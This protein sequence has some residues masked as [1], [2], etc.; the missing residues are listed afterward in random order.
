MLSKDF[1]KWTLITSI[2]FHVVVVLG[3]SF[4]MPT[5]EDNPVIGPPLRI[6]LVSS[7]SELEPDNTETLAQANSAGEEDAAA[8]IPVQIQPTR[9][10]NHSTQETA[11]QNDSVLDS[12]FSESFITE[13]Q[14]IENLDSTQTPLT[15]EQLTQE[16]NLA[17]LNAQAQPREKYVSAR[18]K[19]SIYAA[20][21]EKWRLLVERV[22]NLNY[23]EAAKQQKLEGT[24]VLD[25]A[26]NHRGDVEKVRVLSSSGIKVLD[27]AATRIVHI[28]SP[29]DRFPDSIKKEID[30]LH[31][32]RTWE[33][34][35]DQSSSK[36]GVQ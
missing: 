22:G 20:Y 17:Y 23:P 4:V 16:I 29:Y 32:V 8:S 1:F 10:Q 21:L 2:V 14:K 13:S 28:A 25:V 6:T 3:I 15:R 35:Q 31:I 7:A 11:E 18:A 5:Q 12:A 9:L 30:I 36:M 24:L 27:D 34:G 33:F 26:I 19:E